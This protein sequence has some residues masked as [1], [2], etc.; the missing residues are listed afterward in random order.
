MC[1]KNNHKTRTVNKLKFVY[2]LSLIS[3]VGH[4]VQGLPGSVLSVRHDCVRRVQIH[5]HLQKMG[6]IIPILGASFS[7]PRIDFAATFSRRRPLTSKQSL[8]VAEV[9]QDES[10]QVAL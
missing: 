5:K 3:K 8:R 6:L 1:L 2:Y 9:G 4:M 7:Y 10:R